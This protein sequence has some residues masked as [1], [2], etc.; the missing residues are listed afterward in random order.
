MKLARPVVIGILAFAIASSLLITAFVAFAAKS[1]FAAQFIPE[2]FSARV[3]QNST[4]ASA[5]VANEPTPEFTASPEPTPTLEVPPP[6]PPPVS[7]DAFNQGL[8]LRRDADYAHA[9]ESFRA[10]LRAYPEPALAREARFRL[11]ESLW[12]AGDYANAAPALNA[13]I[14]ENTDDSFAAR[15]HYF[16]AD[17]LTKQR[18]YNSALDHLRAYRAH[19]HALAGDLDAE[20]ADVMLAAGNPVGAISQYGIALKDTTLPAAARVAILKKIAN[21]HSKLGEPGL[22]AARLSEALTLAPNDKTAADVEYQ[23][24]VALEASRQHVPAVAHWQHALAT[25]TDTDGGF[26][27]LAALV[28]AGEP[29]NDYLRGLADYYHE[30]YDGAA[31]AFARYVKANPN[32]NAEAH[33]FT[34]LAYQKNGDAAL[35]VKSFDEIIN[36]HPTDTRVRDAWYGKAGAQARAGDLAGAL[37]SYRQFVTLYPTD[38]RADDALWLA[39]NA[40][41]DAGRLNEAASEYERLVARFPTSSWAPAALFDAGWDY[42]LAKDNTAATTRWTS[43]LKTYPLSTQASR[44]GYWLGKLARTNGDENAARD[45]FQQATKPAA[46]YYSWRARDALGAAPMNGEFDQNTYV[47]D[48]ASDLAEFEKWL[49]SWSRGGA[50]SRALPS[51]VQNNPRFARGAE[52]ANL[53]R[54]SDADDEFKVVNETFKSDPRALYALARYYQDNNY[55]YRSIQAA[56]LI[57]SLSGISNDEQLPRYLRQLIY[58]TY[59][60]DLVVP[61]AEKHGFD[62]ALYF[63][64]IRQESSFDPRSKSW[65][66]AT[67]LTQVMPKTGQGIASDLGVRGFA[68]SD[69]YKPYVSVRFGAHFFGQLVRYF[70]GNIFYSLMGY[71]GGPGTAKKWQRPDVDVS[72][73]VIHLPESYLYVRTVYEQYQ[74]YLEIYRGR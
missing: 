20:L 10:V 37:A 44:A 63:A 53:D 14:S 29:V 33:Y 71:N 17:I 47:M 11:G 23:W 31:Q 25:F 43:L 18:A 70:N 13:V 35:A 6:T 34:A 66:G 59:Y 39:A 55:F 60:A 7:S 36:T 5:A 24:G 45:F 9:A 28:A 72:V 48:S 8:A 56:K 19:S 15:S 41:E 67:G 26:D 42:Y 2:V 61:Y 74:Q 16:L 21:V 27:A 38:P 69:L 3:A 68:S 50:V 4:P 54:A 64:L 51:T 57:K 40:L 22:A 73:E 62:P 30:S 32:H 49:A 46:N 12:L 65:V 1:D 52:L 58:P